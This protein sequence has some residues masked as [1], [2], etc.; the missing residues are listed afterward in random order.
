MRPYRL[1][2]AC[3]I[4]VLMTFWGCSQSD[5]PG[6]PGDSGDSGDAT[7]SSRSVDIPDIAIKPGAG[8]LYII[9]GPH[10]PEVVSK[11]FYHLRR[12]FPLQSFPLGL[13]LYAL[14][15]SIANYP[16]V[17]YSEFDEIGRAHV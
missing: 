7:P 10:S 2:L 17:G 14:M 4:A 8:A 16:V 11:G 12:Q 15:D 1:R 9:T 13:H 3:I 6:K 5:Q